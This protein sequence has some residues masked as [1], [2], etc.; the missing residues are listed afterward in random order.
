ML[1]QQILFEDL[2]IENYFA[3]SSTLIS[4][5]G[6]HLILNLMTVSV[7]KEWAKSQKYLH[8]FYLN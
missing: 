1:L 3:Y 4:C 8:E 6:L 2:N 7:N 5:L